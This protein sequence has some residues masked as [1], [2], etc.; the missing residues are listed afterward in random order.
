[1]KYL[2]LSKPL[3]EALVKRLINGWHLD[4][5]PEGWYEDYLVYAT[6]A[7]SNDQ[8][9]LEWLMEIHNEQ[10]FGNLPPTDEL[11]VNA[12]I[13]VVSFSKE[14]PRKESVWT[15]GIQGPVYE[16]FTSCVFDK[17]F[18]TD[19]LRT[20]LDL[21]AM[22]PSH[23]FCNVHR[24]HKDIFLTLY[25]GDETFSLATAGGTIMLDLTDEIRNLIL[26]DPE[27]EADLRHFDIL[28]LVCGKREK[29]FD[30]KDGIEIIYEYGD[31]G[32]PVTY[33]S[34]KSPEKRLMRISVLISCAKPK[35]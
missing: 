9:P 14:P 31:D 21:G 22:L 20:D 33:P 3:A 18:R 28:C 27:N 11:P 17:P 24:P 16:V 4:E 35:R 7:V 25:V 12:F 2:K 19:H 13:G 26:L 5:A 23:V 6:E 32:N 29:L 30:I 8:M 10:V 15:Q 34:V 1:M